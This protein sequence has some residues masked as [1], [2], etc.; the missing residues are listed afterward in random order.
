MDNF[1]ARYRAIVEKDWNLRC[2]NLRMD[3]LLFEQKRAEFF[4]GWTTDDKISFV[5]QDHARSAVCWW[6]AGRLPDNIEFS[7]IGG[8]CCI[9]TDSMTQLVVNYTDPADA[10]LTAWEIILGIKEKP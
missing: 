6:L 10:I 9:E 7:L 5:E 1:E 2:P 8:S 4:Q 3:W